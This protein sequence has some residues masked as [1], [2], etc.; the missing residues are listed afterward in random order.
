MR[1]CIQYER[2]NAAYAQLFH[3]EENVLAI[4]TIYDFRPLAVDVTDNPGN[5]MTICSC[6][7]HQQMIISP[8]TAIVQT[9]V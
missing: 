7:K 2:L 3:V 1:S 9:S 5:V 8:N 4:V 6:D